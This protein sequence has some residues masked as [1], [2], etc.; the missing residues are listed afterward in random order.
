[1]N[2]LNTLPTTYHSVPIVRRTATAAL[3]ELH[4]RQRAGEVARSGPLQRITA[5]PYAGHY[6]I[7]V[8]LIVQ[9][10]PEPA[11]SRRLI[12][13]G[14]ALMGVSGFFLMVLWLIT[15]L[16]GW[17]L[18]MLCS[19]VLGAFLMWLKVKYFSRGRSFTFSGQ[20]QMR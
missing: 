10:R 11:L 4:A 19:T 5:G 2:K 18:F 14:L 16:S 6:A 8:T 13:V 15:S 1:M 3:A 17:A 20:G 12:V 7:P 9:S